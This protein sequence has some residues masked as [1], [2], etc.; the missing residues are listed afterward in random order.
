MAQQGALDVTTNNI[1]NVNTP[2]YSR[3]Q[4]QLTEEPPINVGDL[5]YGDGVSLSDIQGVRDN[6]LQLQI[7]QQT[8][9]QNR[10]DSYLSSMQQVSTL[11]NET[12]GTG[13][14]SVIDSFFTS[15]Q[16]LET[17]P[18]SMSLRQAVLTA[19]QSMTAAFQQT[20][21]SLDTIQSGLNQQVTQ[22]VNS[23]N[24]L[25]SQIASLNAQIGSLS[26]SGQG[27]QQLIDQQNL[28]VNQLSQLIDISASD[29]GNGSLTITT[30]GGALLVAGTSAL[31][32]GTS[33][34]PTSGN[35]DVTSQGT[36][37]TGQIAG[38]QLGGLLEAR[39]QDIP[40]VQAN[41]DNL[42]A[43]LTSAVNTA[44][45]QG[46]DLTGAQGGNFFVPFVQ[47]VPGSNAGAAASFAVALTD[48][49][50]IAASSGSGGTDSG[51]LGNL[52]GVQNQPLFNGE[53]V[54][55]AY[56][57]LVAGIGSSISNATAE[58]Q[59]ENLVVQQLQDQQSSISGVSINE[60]SANLIRYQ[61]AFEAAAKVVTVVDD[62]TNTV[63]NSMGV[64]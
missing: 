63:I 27:A 28:A 13:L 21:T 33:T 45:Q 5:S 7:D 39:D 46:F 2:G 4:A 3:E 14:Q 62:L 19:G 17:D 60:E 38:G 43:G 40:S 11:F 51:N 29:S 56:S 18:T 36:D 55:V 24:G 59:A 22:A 58:S 35:T 6:V 10:L 49:S 52:A 47:T 9:N 1:A 61:Q 23:V 16:S 48:P 20:A 12:Q 30:T 15:F 25:T 8:Q 37:I 26:G 50:Q 64:S 32:L 31:Q 44:N 53:T 42:A 41:L 34:D 54:D 57:G